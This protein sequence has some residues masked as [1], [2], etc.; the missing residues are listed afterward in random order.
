MSPDSKTM[1]P[2]TRASSIVASRWVGAPHTTRSSG[3][4][5]AWP[6]ASIPTRIQKT[7]RHPCRFREITEAYEV[8]R[9]PATT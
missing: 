9:R 2:A 4:T 8:L 3:R 5:D 6:S 1:A 7:P